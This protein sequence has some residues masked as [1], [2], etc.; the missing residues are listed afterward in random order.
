[1]DLYF[2]LLSLI[3]T[4]APKTTTMKKTLLS[5]WLL[6]M[7]A[8]VSA[9]TIV[10]GDMNGDGELTITDAVKVVNVIL[11]NAPKQAIDLDDPYRV[12]NTL[13]VGTWYAPG[14]MW[15]DFN[16]DGTTTYPGGVT[17]EFMPVQGRLLIYDAEENP[18]KVL[19][20]VKVKKEY[21][22]AADYTTGT[23]TKYIAQHHGEYVDLGL[24]SGTL[25]ATCNIG[26]NSPEDY[27]DYFAWGET[28]GH[29]S[30][31]NNF[32]QESYFD[33]DNN[34]ST[35]KKYNN[36]GGLTELKPEDDAAY[37]NWGPSWC[38]PTNDQMNELRMNCR[39]E[40]VTKNN[41]D[42]YEVKGP[43]ENSIFLP[44]GGYYGSSLTEAGVKGYYWSSTLH[45]TER[46]GY[47][48]RLIFDTA[49]ISMDYGSRY[50]GRSVRPVRVQQRTR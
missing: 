32:T 23:F 16:E 38:M 34:S 12:D 9:Q 5:F 29:D 3:R 37:M 47:A 43:N 49:G 33:Y 26:A 8:S 10:K 31:K 21:L 27:G 17:Y 36:N 2:V 44:A 25:W 30:G 14:V 35:Y 15:F 7:V 22:L 41:V 13:V 50:Y 42:G 1:M 24:P 11:G 39:W 40:W 6:I 19:P 18:V 46:S 48:C 4:F 45:S 20:L 28:K